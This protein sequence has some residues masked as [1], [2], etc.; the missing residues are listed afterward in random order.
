MRRAPDFSGE[1]EPKNVLSLHLDLKTACTM[2]GFM[3]SFAFYTSWQL[4]DVK[5]SIKSGTDDRWRKSHMREYTHRIR[6]LNEG[7]VKVPDV[8]DIAR[9]MQDQ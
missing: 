2:L 9:S 8:D 7:K 4:W 5:Q 3:A 1:R 6:D